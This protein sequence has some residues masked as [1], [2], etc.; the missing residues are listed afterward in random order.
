M[1]DNAWFPVN[2]LPLPFEIVIG[3]SNYDRFV[4]YFGLRPWISISYRAIATHA[5]N[6][7]THAGSTIGGLF[8][9]L[10]TTTHG[11]WARS[12]LHCSLTRLKLTITSSMR[13][14]IHH[15]DSVDR[16]VTEK[17]QLYDVERVPRLEVRKEVMKALKSSS[18][19][20]LRDRS[21]GSYLNSFVRV[22]A[23]HTSQCPDYYQ[24]E[25]MSFES[26]S[27]RYKAWT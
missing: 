17:N 18:L 14:D 13:Y 8:L 26:Y 9:C 2:S 19:A 21:P 23:I 11:Q 7:S 20:S 4:F 1:S 3:R 12:L 16:Y 5:D 27:K 22:V 15:C 25:G 6:N 24:L 10:M